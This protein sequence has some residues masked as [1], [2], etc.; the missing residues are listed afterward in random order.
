MILADVK[1]NSCPLAGKQPL[2]VE[3]LAY[4]RKAVYFS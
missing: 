2:A 3:I 1:N 4:V